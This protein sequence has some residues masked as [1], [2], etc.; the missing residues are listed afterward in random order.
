M[1]V[2]FPKF[3]IPAIVKTI[4]KIAVSALIIFL[5]LRKIDER[6]LFE[7]LKTTNPL[8]LLWAAVWFIVSKII[9]AFRFNLLLKTEDLH[10]S[11]KQNLKLYWLGMYYNLLLP[12]G[13]S[14]DGYK[15]KVL[16][17][18][19][20]KPLKGL[21]TISLIDRFSGIVALFQLCLL[22]VP[23][24]PSLEKYQLYSVT[25]FVLS[26][27]LLWLGYKYAGKSITPVWKQTTLL[28]AGVQLAQTV[29]AL[30]LVFALQQQVHW[31]GYLLLFL[32]S[33]VVAMFPFTIGGA[34]ARELT[35]LYGAGLLG[36]QQEK[37]VAIGF[38]FYL[39][40]TAVAFYG[41]VYSFKKIV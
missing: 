24:V 2:S 4:I 36:L 31:P 16:M 1:N 21:V 28:S 37:A 13:I 6:L 9:G 25:L 3:R 41:I 26:F 15:I 8:W 30:G 34:G 32:I 7:L 14:G 27:A 38:L 35:F 10:L 11:H 22:L 18:A 29:A 19:Y 17:D 20:R 39:I 5:V 23:F 40:S 12:G 33:S